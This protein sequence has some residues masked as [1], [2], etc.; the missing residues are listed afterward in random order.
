L[1]DGTRF[2]DADRPA[3]LSA[4]PH[5]CKHSWQVQMASVEKLLGLDFTAVLPGGA[6]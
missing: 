4:F 5:V 3:R 1:V 2:E 6:A